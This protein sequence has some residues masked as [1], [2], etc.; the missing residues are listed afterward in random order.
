MKFTLHIVIF[1]NTMVALKSFE[2]EN[3]TERLLGKI[4]L[5]LILQ[6]KPWIT[7]IINV[8]NALVTIIS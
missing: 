7:S 5:F 6:M 4:G 8:V 2:S 3:D 1:L